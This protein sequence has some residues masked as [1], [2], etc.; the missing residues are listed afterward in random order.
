MFFDRFMRE[1]PEYPDR[2]TQLA[3]TPDEPITVVRIHYVKTG[4]EPQFEAELKKHMDEFD[5][6][7]ANLGISIFRPGKYHDGV[8]RIV[9]KFA[10]REAL[11]QWHASPTYLAWIKIEQNLTIAPPCTELLTGLETWF[12][13]PGQNVL[14]P[15]TKA[16]QAVVTWIA[17]LPVS[18]IISL[19]TDPFLDPQPFLVQKV[20]FLSLLVVLLT[21]V[22]MPLVTRLFARWLFPAETLPSGAEGEIDG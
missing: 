9:Y 16:R 5:A 14:K 8:Y 10:S 19:V 3:A 20:V 12:T 18:I 11:D 4:C 21:W 6:I 17:A 2:V 22:V 15:P 7:P 13:L 1:S